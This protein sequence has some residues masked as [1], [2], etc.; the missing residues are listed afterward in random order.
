[1]EYGQPGKLTQAPSLGIRHLTAYMVD[2]HL[3]SLLVPKPLPT[4]I[5]LLVFLAWVAVPTLRRSRV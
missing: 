4:N 3:Q 1:M 2:L 5:S